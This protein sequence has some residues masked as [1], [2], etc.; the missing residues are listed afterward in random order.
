[1][2]NSYSLDDLRSE[3]EK[4]F[5]PV[6]IGLSDGSEVELKSLLRLGKKTRDL[7]GD[8]LEDL[9]SINSDDDDD[10]E[11]N[12]AEAELLVEAIAKILNLIASSPAKLLKE[13]DH[14]DALIKVTLMTQVLNKWIGGAQ[15]GEAGNSPA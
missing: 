8:T 5:A 15:V 11:L 1:M 9:K 7:V 14:P 12:E 10:E 2:S 6:K 4:K 3:T 13:L